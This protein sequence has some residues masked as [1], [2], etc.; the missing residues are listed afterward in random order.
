MQNLNHSFKQLFADRLPTKEDFSKLV[1]CVAR[2]QEI[3]RVSCVAPCTLI[4]ATTQDVEVN[5]YKIP[6]DTMIVANIAKFL[7]DPDAFPE[8]E[9]L[10]PERFIKKSNN[11]LQLKVLFSSDKCKALIL[12]LLYENI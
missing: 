3:Q 2:I 5:D 12:I 11:K 6:K 7:M 10:K 8:P 9:Q 4:H 1:Y